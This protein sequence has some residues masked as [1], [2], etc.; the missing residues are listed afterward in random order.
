MLRLTFLHLSVKERDE[1]E[2]NSPKE[3]MT[4][5]LKKPCLRGTLVLKTA[6]LCTGVE[7][8]STRQP[9]QHN[10]AHLSHRAT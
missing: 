4:V 1:A 5:Q 7:R 2:K 6:S 10:L 9:G 8:E 3:V